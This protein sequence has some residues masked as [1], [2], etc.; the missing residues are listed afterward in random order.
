[1]AGNLGLGISIFKFGVHINVG[2]NLF[3][4]AMN[5]I[6]KAEIFYI[7]FLRGLINKIQNKLIL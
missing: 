5:I 6:K 4:E 1:L 3:R 2:D 7:D